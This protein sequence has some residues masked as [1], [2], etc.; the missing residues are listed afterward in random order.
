MHHVSLEIELLAA[1]STQIRDGVSAFDK[2]EGT[3]H[4]LMA[5]PLSLDFNF[6]VFQMT[7]FSK[8]RRKGSRIP[9]IYDVVTPVIDMSRIVN[10]GV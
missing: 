8:K 1:H 3:L 6:F 5:L 10:V 9:S 4:Q 2:P 7:A